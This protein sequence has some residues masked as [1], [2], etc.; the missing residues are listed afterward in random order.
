MDE[1]EIRDAF[2]EFISGVMKNYTKYLTTPNEAEMSTIEAQHFFN[3]HQFRK[4]KDGGTK[5]DSFIFQLTQTGLFSNFIENR[6]FGKSEFD[7]EILFFD[8]CLK[9]RRTKKKPRVLQ[10][11]QPNRIVKA[12][13]PQDFDIDNSQ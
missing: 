2:L 8:S 11:P 13:Q 12:N 1:L 7:E 4:A 6:S 9:D 10:P 5:E 3:F